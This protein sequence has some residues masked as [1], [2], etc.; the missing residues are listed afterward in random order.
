MPIVEASCIKLR[1]E[2][3]TIEDKAASLDRPAPEVNED[4]SLVS[5]LYVGVL[6]DFM[7]YLG[8]DDRGTLLLTFRPLLLG[9]RV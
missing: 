9:F 2:R 6:A 3:F 8:K 4:E 1:I 7:A 5:Q